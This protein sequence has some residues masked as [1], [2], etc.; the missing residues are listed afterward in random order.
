MGVGP[1]SQAAIVADAPPRAE[2]DGLPHVHAGRSDE[3]AVRHPASGPAPGA[4]GAWQ[5]NVDPKHVWVGTAKD[6][7]IQ[8][9]TG[10]VLGDGPQYRDFD[11]QRI[12][13][14]TSGH[15]GYWDMGPNGAASE[16]LANQGRIIA[17]R[18]PTLA[19]TV[20]H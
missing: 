4:V 12:Q 3:L 6:D 20:P 2:A 13:I 8:M 17:S 7:F 9:V 18:Q 11:A 14:D 5:L 15:G 1:P 19:P 16:S 10:T